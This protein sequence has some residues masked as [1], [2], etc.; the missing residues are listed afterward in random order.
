MA[1][2]AD[3]QASVSGYVQATGTTGVVCALNPDGTKKW[4]Y[5]VGKGETYATTGRAV[6]YYPLRICLVRENVAGNMS[7]RAERSNLPLAK[8]GIASSPCSSQ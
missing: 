8:S 5:A 6:R 7:L 4:T 3:E 2:G 1:R